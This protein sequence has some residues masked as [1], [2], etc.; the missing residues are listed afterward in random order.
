M[1]T[2]TDSGQR[3]AEEQPDAYQRA[4]HRVGQIRGFY[5]NLFSYLVIVAFL[6]VV[7]LLTDRTYPWFLWVAAG[8]GVAVA[9]HAYATFANH[10]LFGREWEER[11]IQEIMERERSERSM[12]PEQH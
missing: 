6:A 10:G 7:N 5:S 1:Y 8:W 4:R 2:G 11:K 9:F 12:K 3:G